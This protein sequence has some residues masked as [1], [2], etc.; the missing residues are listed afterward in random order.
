[1]AR[2][3]PSESILMQ[4]MNGESISDVMFSIG[5]E[6][7]ASVVK[8]K[9]LSFVYTKLNLLSLSSIVTDVES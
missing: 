4:A 8:R 2:V 5:M 1:M 9:C 7:V 3:A 6:N